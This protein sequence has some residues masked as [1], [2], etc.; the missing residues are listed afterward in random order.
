MTRQ[1]VAG[2]VLATIGMVLFVVVLWA[3]YCVL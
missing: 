3:L 1:E 2:E